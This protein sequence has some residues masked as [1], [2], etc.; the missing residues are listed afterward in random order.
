MLDPAAPQLEQLLAAGGRDIGAGDEDGA[1]R[2]LDEPGEARTSVDL[3]LPDRPITTKTSPGMTSMSMSRIATT[4]PVLASS[5]ARG[6]SASGE[7]TMR[8]A[9]GPTPS[10]GLGPMHRLCVHVP[11]SSICTL[12]ADHRQRGRAASGV[13]RVGAA[14]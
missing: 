14:R 9:L 4:Q 13:S 12:A 2:R 8:S 11:P 7:P 3:P 10:R 6:R 5:S 1:G